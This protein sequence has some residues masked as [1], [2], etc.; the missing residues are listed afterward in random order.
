MDNS[1]KVRFKDSIHSR[2]HLCQKIWLFSFMQVYRE[3]DLREDMHNLQISNREASCPHSYEIRIRTSHTWQKHHLILSAKH[4]FIQSQEQFS[5]RRTLLFIF[6]QKRLRNV[7]K[8]TELIGGRCE[9]QTQTLF[10]L[11]GVLLIALTEDLYR[12][13]LC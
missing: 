9:I 10:S 2:A 7:L 3:N 6:K 5:E 12:G 4:H 8:F 1:L 13:K 11:E